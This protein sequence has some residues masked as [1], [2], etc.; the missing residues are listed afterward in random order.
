MS[1]LLSLDYSPRENLLTEKLVIRPLNKDPDQ[2]YFDINTIAPLQLIARALFGRD[3]FLETWPRLFTDLQG[4]EEDPKK[5]TCYATSPLGGLLERTFANTNITD[6]FIGYPCSV[7]NE[8]SSI[9]VAIVQWLWTLV[10]VGDGILSEAFDAAA[11]LAIRAWMQFGGTWS[12]DYQLNVWYDMGQE[13]VIPAISV[14][15]IVLNSAL[16]AAYLGSLL[17]LAI[18]AYRA[19]RWTRTLD[20]FAMMR[21][22]SAVAE[23]VPLLAG[24]DVNK[25]DVLDV[26]PGRIGD[27]AGDDED[28]AGDGDGDAEIGRLTLGGRAPLGFDR[29]YRCYEGME[30]LMSEVEGKEMKLKARALRALGRPFGRW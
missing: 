13:T 26:I 6:L 27:G 16:L 22:G 3:S 4:P 23:H 11:F 5:I 28:G 1:F 15:G 18:Y 9:N 17:W 7:S 30:E 12:Y 2:T 21:I 10:N 25:L 24:R 14:Q 20:A 8:V 29:P 19:P